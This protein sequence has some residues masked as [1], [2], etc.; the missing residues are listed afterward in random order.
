MLTDY[1]VDQFAMA[2]ELVHHVDVTPGSR[3][4]PCLCTYLI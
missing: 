2:T 4:L 1:V 3:L